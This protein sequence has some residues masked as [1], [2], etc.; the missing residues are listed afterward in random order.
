MR[1][2]KLTAWLLIFFG[3][4]LFLNHFDLF[5]FSRLTIAEGLSLLLAVVFINRSLHNSDRKGILGAVFFILFLMILLAM[6]IGI[7]PVNDRLGSG[8][9]LL[10][11]SLS[12]LV[13]FLVGRKKMSNLIW[14]FL[15]FVGGLPFIINYFD[16]MPLW[17][18]EDFYSTYWPALLILIGVIILADSFIKR[19]KSKPDT[20]HTYHG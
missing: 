2:S 1:K 4:V 15:F 14:T 6:Q 5:D 13:C 10:S 16:L 8:L 7:I 11:L 20:E 9:V 17:I 12:N 3:V 19:K 18:V